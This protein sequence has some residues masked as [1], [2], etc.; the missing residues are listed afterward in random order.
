MRARSN[1]YAAARLGLEAEVHWL[2]WKQLRI[3]QLILQQ[4]LP[5]A[6]R[7]LALLG[8]DRTE[9]DHW[10][11]IIEA[12]V[13]T[14]MNGA[15]WQRAWVARHGRDMAALSLAYLERQESG[16]PVHEWGF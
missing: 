13:K 11:G 7:G 1:F 8:V 3:D 14:K 12:R 5:K 4:L 10:L 2:D 9:S 16:L 15:A 6:R